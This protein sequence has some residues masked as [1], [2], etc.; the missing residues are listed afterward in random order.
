MP[1]ECTHR[2]NSNGNGMN[3]CEMIRNSNIL[4]SAKEISSQFASFSASALPRFHHELFGT[5]CLVPISIDLYI[6]VVYVCCF[7]FFS[8][9]CVRPARVSRWFNAFFDF[10]VN[11]TVCSAHEPLRFYFSYTYSYILSFFFR[12]VHFQFDFFRW[13]SNMRTCDT[14]LQVIPFI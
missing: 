8:R 14:A 5:K 11:C 13:I 10:C 9:L 2:L 7:F 1:N 6:H 12:M 3:G 4:T